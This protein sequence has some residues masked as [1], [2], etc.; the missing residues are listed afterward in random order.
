VLRPPGS[1][2]SRRVNFRLA[3]VEI[4]PPST[5]VLLRFRLSRTSCPL[6]Q[7]RILSIAEFTGGAPQRSQVVST[8]M[9]F[10]KNRHLYSLKRPRREVS[11]SH[12]MTVFFITYC[13]A[14]M[15]NGK[16]KTKA[17]RGWSV[18]LRFV[19]SAGGCCKRMSKGS[20]STAIIS[21][22]SVR[23][24]LLSCPWMILATIIIKQD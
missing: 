5:H 23:L 1:S 12:R 18:S 19:F 8:P 2:A 7:F 9:D 4:G 16:N 3:S 21:A 17:K 22:P 11:F 14:A 6:I 10:T 24:R 13:M 15:I 20:L